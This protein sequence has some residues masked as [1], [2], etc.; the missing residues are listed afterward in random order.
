MQKTD[1]GSIP[2]R[3]GSFILLNDT[4]YD[5]AF[6]LSLNVNILDSYFDILKGEIREGEHK[7]E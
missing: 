4:I 7:E 2:P 6:V 3:I 5:Y 1:Y